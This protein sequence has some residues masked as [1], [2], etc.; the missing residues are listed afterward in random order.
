M[1]ITHPRQE[2]KAVVY[3]YEVQKNVRARGK[4]VF[5]GT[6][7][8]NKSGE[9][10]GEGGIESLTGNLSKTTTELAARACKIGLFNKMVKYG[11]RKTKNIG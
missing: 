10:R 8:Y 5:N 4:W 9:G 11:K 7:K 3:S 1:R 6:E 2:N